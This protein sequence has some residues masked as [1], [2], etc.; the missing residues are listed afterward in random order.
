MRARAGRVESRHPFCMAVC[1][2]L[3]FAQSRQLINELLQL[4]VVSRLKSGSG[5][6]AEAVMNC[7]ECGS[8]ECVRYVIPSMPKVPRDKV[9][10]QNTH[11]GIRF[12]ASS[13]VSTARLASWA[14]S[15]PVRPRLSVSLPSSSYAFAS[16]F[17]IRSLKGG[18]ARRKQ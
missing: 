16:E 7:S 2:S 8:E 10:F 3:E 14:R 15:K 9:F 6:G 12:L 5:S 17:S 4:L 18:K 11:V 13:T 1:L